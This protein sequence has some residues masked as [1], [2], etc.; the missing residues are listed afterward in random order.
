[1]SE[2]ISEWGDKWV[3]EWLN[4]SMPTIFHVDVKSMIIEEE[5]WLAVLALVAYCRTSCSWVYDAV[6]FSDCSTAVQAGLKRAHSNAGAKIVVACLRSPASMCVFPCEAYIIC[7][8]RRKKG[9]GNEHRDW[10]VRVSGKVVRWDEM[11]VWIIVVRVKG[12][13]QSV[14][15]LG[16]GLGISVFVW[17]WF[18]NIRGWV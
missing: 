5:S 2:W 15:G 3:S 4:I 7:I 18:C 13:R 1:M 8:Q 10:V 6:A 11:R 17:S 14:P 9:G 16:L 12:R